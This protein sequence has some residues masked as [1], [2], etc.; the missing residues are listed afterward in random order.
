MKKVLYLTN[1]ETPYRVRFFNELAQKCDL[2]VLYE[3]KTSSN[4]DRTWAF[5]E[6]RKHRT[7]SLHGIPWKTENA[8]S[9][10]IAKEV[11]SGYD[12]VIVGCLNSPVQI[13]AMILMRMLRKPYALNLDGE[14]FL[15]GASLKARLK[16]FFLKGATQY[17]VAGE[18]SARSAGR[19]L[20]DAAEIIPYYFSS[21]S[22]AEV[23]AN[24]KTAGS[25]Q[26]DNTVLVVGQYI[27]CKGMDVALEAA[28]MDPQIQYK[29]VG[30]GQRTALFTNEHE[31]PANVQVI[32]FLQ[33]AD[34]EQEYRRC[35]MLVLPSRQE[36]WG[37]VINEA[38]SFGMP[39]VSTWGSGAAVEFLGEE[40]P[41]YLA[42]PGDAWDLLRC[43]RL[44]RQSPAAEE[45]SQA[46]VEKAKKY[47]IEKSVQ[48]HSRTIG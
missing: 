29:F 14:P 2:T 13:L 18:E 28:R 37:L 25:C 42:K 10:G 1:I 44:L 46:L 47:T 11:L 36:C 32:P 19:V 15:E 39:I 16:R 3:R 22:E 12:L 48:I 27:D 21:L 23:E 34:L 4:R 38:A 24:G 40:Y 20:G 41:Q 9:L 33:K 26:R 31:I 30:M 35:G 7:K 6:E 17:L 8:I 45:Y 43:I 5:S